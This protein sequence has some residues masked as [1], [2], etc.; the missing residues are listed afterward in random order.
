M[1][2]L[3]LYDMPMDNKAKRK[4]YVRFRDFILD[5]G[6]LMMQFSVYTRICPN[7]SS[8]EKH[9]ARVESFHP[10]YGNIRIMKITENQYQS[11]I[12]VNGEKD[13][14]ELLDNNDDLVII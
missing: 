8:A 6:F 2:L 9:I 4:E 12:M 5:D 3:V 13:E 11:M 10:K 14:Q 7:E 1:R